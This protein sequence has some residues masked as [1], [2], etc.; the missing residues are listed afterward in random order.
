MEPSRRVST[1]AACKRSAGK[2]ALV[3]VLVW[4]VILGAP[5]N[6]RARE[7]VDPFTRAITLYEKGKPKQ[8]RAAVR[9][10][11]LNSRDGARQLLGRK[12]PRLQEVA[13]IPEAIMDLTSKAVEWELKSAGAGNVPAEALALLETARLTL[14]AISA[15]LPKRETA[16]ADGKYIIDKYAYG[17]SRVIRQE[18]S[19]LKKANM[20]AKAE[21]LERKYAMILKGSRPTPVPDTPYFI[22]T[23]H[24]RPGPLQ[25]VEACYVHDMPEAG[26]VRL[27]ALLIQMRQDVAE[28]IKAGKLDAK[29]VSVPEMM[30]RY[31]F[32]AISSEAAKLEKLALL[33]MTIEIIE[34]VN[35]QVVRSLSE[36]Q[37]EKLK[38][39]LARS[40][41]WLG[42]LRNHEQRW[43]GRCKGWATAHGKTT[44]P[45]PKPGIS[46]KSGRLPF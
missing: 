24:V 5:R 15:Q 3:A 44:R 14:A 12:P 43:R 29:T 31:V 2:I 8:A 28:R 38:V 22:K 6:T 34:D 27:L 19:L 16:D 33:R 17:L 9:A 35:A 25:A 37:K 32:D 36:K 13:P 1:Q 26:R 21:A 39:N 20:T 10:L 40:Q 46:N 4:P 45:E 30:A 23:S 42:R 11:I 41:D 18:I 7:M